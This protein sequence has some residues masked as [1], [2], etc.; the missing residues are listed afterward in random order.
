MDEDGIIDGNVTSGRL[1][2]GTRYLKDFRLDFDNRNNAL[3]ADVTGSAINLGGIELKDNHIDAMVDDD[4]ISLTYTFDNK[5]EEANKAELRLSADLARD[6]DGLAV[7][8]SVL[9]SSVYYYG[10]RWQVD[11][12]DLTL[13]GGDLRVDRFRL[14]NGRQSLVVDGGLSPTKNDTLSVRMDQFDIS[15]LDR[16]RA[17]P[18]SFPRP[19]RHWPCS[20]ASPATPRTWPAG[21]WAPW[22]WPASG[23]NPRNGSTSSSGT[24]RTVS[25]T[26]TWTVTSVQRTRPSGPLR[27]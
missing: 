4:R 3:H 6:A 1:A 18:A 27:R 16:Q 20:P 12:D 11:S 22:K 7:V 19:S 15:L 23:M 26:S 21:P 25:G 2:L 17:G 24:S 14:R 10:D 5:T 9:P 8:A 13:Q